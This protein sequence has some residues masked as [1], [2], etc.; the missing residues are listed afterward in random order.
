MCF[1]SIQI[2]PRYVEPIKVER[3]ID[4]LNTPRGRFQTS[5]LIAVGNTSKYVGDE[6]CDQEGVT[7]KWLIYVKMKTNIIAVEDIVSKAR[8]YLH[9]SFKPNDVVEVE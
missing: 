9:P 8:F 1:F 3:T 7:H 2:K 6:K 4:K 5:H